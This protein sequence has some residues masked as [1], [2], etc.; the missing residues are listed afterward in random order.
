MVKARGSG[1]TIRIK[2]NNKNTITINTGRSEADAVRLITKKP[3]S[4][5]DSVLRR[6][7]IP[8]DVPMPKITKNQRRYYRD[9]LSQG[10]VVL[11]DLSRFKE[12]DGLGEFSDG[13]S[14]NCLL[15]IGVNGTLRKITGY[16]REGI[17]DSLGKRGI[18]AHHPEW[19]GKIQERANGER[20]AKKKISMNIRVGLDGRKAVVVNPGASNGA[21]RATS[22]NGIRSLDEVLKRVKVPS[23]I[24]LR[25]VTP[26]QEKAYRRLLGEGEVVLLNLQKL[27]PGS[28]LKRLSKGHSSMCLLGIQVNGTI[29]KVEMNAGRN[30]VRHL[31]ARRISAYHP[32]ELS[33]MK[34]TYTQTEEQHKRGKKTAKR[35]Y[36]ASELGQATE[37]AYRERTRDE[38]R[39]KNKAYRATGKG[40]L[41]DRLHT[42]RQTAKRRIESIEMRVDRIGERIKNAEDVR[43]ARLRQWKAY[44]DELIKKGDDVEK[45]L[46]AA[47][48]G[49]RRRED[50]KVVRAVEKLESVLNETRLVKR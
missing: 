37:R 3:V 49:I 19:L 46:E 12:T 20:P 27:R 39:R 41:A 31:K 50:K 47:P 18:V 21:I 35:K 16:A 29:R 17:L 8:P 26:W 22:R 15:G 4:S 13:F 11:L 1:K 38:G 48:K 34:F 24:A 32:Y 10:N 14:R 42:A 36:K 2:R 45:A 43:P 5:V 30:I 28:E 33:R 6:V 40:K 23:D 9:M 7:K 25:G 44:R